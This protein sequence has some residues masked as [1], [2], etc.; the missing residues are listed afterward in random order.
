MASPRRKTRTQRTTPTLKTPQ[1]DDSLV[2][3]QKVLASAGFGSRRHCEEFIQSGRVTVD[4]KTVVELGLRVDPAKQKIQLDGE[5]VNV[6]KKVYYVLN[7]PTGFLCTHSDPAGRRRVIDLFPKAKQRLFTVGRLDENSEGLILVTNDGEFANR[8]AHPRYRVSRVYEVQVAG[9]P[10]PDILRQM[11]EGLR[12]SEGYFRVDRARRVRVKGKTAVLQLTL[13]QG[14]NREIRRLLARLGHKVMKLRRIQFGPI[15]LGKV[16]LGEHRTL[17][18]HEVKQ[19]EALLET[20]R[21]IRSGRPPRKNAAPAKGKRTA[22][23]K[24]KSAAPAKGKR[25]S[26]V[27]GKAAAAAKKRPQ[28]KAT[29]SRRR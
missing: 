6:E 3:L 25:S 12:F 7:K 27:K 20:K 2:R 11:R 26:P 17:T 23:A 13:N 22:P 28:Q 4:G 10:T 18:P 16:N 15:K 8:L 21:E 1:G 24:S 19:L 9:I 5:T 29:K 14:R